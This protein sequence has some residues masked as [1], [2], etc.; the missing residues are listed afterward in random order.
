MEISEFLNKPL[1]EIPPGIRAALHTD[2]PVTLTEFGMKNKLLT[3]KALQREF[4]FARFDNGNYLVS[5][6][7]PMPGITPEMI[8]WWF[9]WH[10]QES[11]RYRIWFPG[12]HYGIFTDR[13]NRAYF[14]EK[15]LP[16]FQPN[17]HY[18]IERIG[19]LVLP[20]K[21]VFCSP[22]DFGFSPSLMR[23]NDIPLIVCGHVSAMYGL[24]NHT[25]MAHIFKQTE[26][27][28]FLISR[29]WLGETLKNPLLRK[30]ILTGETAKGMAAHCCVEYR[31]LDQILP[32][33][34]RLFQ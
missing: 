20:L 14:N 5:M 6:P 7:C 24:V 31:N 33:L 11:I 8:R 27:G 26:D 2:S 18:P 28:L 12:E 16:D 13:V 25:E 3:D 15:T 9:W 21:I 4:G 1:P 23:E 22:E 32:E 30:A 29:F 17:T 10:A 34:Y 19:K